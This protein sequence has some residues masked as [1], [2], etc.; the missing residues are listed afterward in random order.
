M[1]KLLRFVLLLSLGLALARSAPAAEEAQSASALF[2]LTLTSV[3]GQ[4]VALAALAGKPLLVNF[5]ARWCLPCRKEIPDLAAMQRRYA[6]SE[7]TVIG[8]AVEDLEHR[9]AIRDFAQAYEMNYLVLIGGVEGAVELMRLLGNRKSG[10]PFSVII[11]RAGRIQSSKL[12]AMS[13]SEMEA[14]LRPLR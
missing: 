13:L 6:A 3:D 7:L 11:D 8:I 2:A 5:W 1:R 12:G 14:A 9:A 10:L 4:P